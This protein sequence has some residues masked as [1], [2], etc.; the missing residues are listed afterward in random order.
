MGR[1]SE[2]NPEQEVSSELTLRPEAEEELAEAFDWY[3]ERVPGLGSDFLITVDAILRSIHRNPLQYPEIH[4]GA[5]RALLRR[6]PYQVLFVSGSERTV[7]LAI[8]HAKRHPKHWQE[9]T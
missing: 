4:C 5:R 7:I 1:R 6:F 3:E 9:R 8:F 2:P